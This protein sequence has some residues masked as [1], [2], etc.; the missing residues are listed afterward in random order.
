MGNTFAVV[1]QSID[2]TVEVVKSEFTDP[3]RGMPGWHVELKGTREAVMS[4]EALHVA[5]QEAFDADFD[6]F[7][8]R[9]VNNFP[10]I[11][12]EANEDGEDLYTRAFTFYDE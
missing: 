5:E 11:A 6:C 3:M 4:D 8:R 10:V 7:G 1:C 2:M 12:N 9:D